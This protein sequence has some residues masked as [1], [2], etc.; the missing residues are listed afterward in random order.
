MNMFS[1]EVIENRLRARA[2]VLSAALKHGA[3]WEQTSKPELS[4]STVLQCSKSESE[5]AKAVRRWNSFKKPG[6][7]VG[8]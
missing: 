1:Q 4:L 7:K 5:K 8:L 6:L 3:K 2:E